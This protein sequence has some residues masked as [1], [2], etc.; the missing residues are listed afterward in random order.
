MAENKVL[1]ITG[2]ASGIGQH[3]SYQLAKEATPLL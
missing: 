1:I 3:A 2:G